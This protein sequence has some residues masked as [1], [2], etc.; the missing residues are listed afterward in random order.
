MFDA[1]SPPISFKGISDTLMF[2]RGRGSVLYHALNIRGELVSLELHNVYYVPNQPY[3]LIG[4]KLKHE[5]FQG[6]DLEKMTITTSDG[7]QSLQL[8][9]WNGI[10]AL[11]VAL[12]ENPQCQKL[13]TTVKRDTDDWMVVS[14]V[15]DDQN[16]LVLQRNGVEIGVDLT[17]N[18]AMKPEGNSHCSKFFSLLN[19]MFTIQWTG[20]MF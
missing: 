5:G 4:H 17:T 6:A 1:R 12:P 18:G 7:K 14:S 2:S 16:D 8:F 20:D 10:T 13:L 15:F 19:S 3:N 11:K 9:E